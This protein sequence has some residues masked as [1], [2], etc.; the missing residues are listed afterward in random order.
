MQQ[1]K[2]N[3][4]FIF[5]ILFYSGCNQSTTE[6]NSFQVEEDIQELPLS[7]EI[8]KEPMH[9][10]N[11]INWV[12]NPQNGLVKIKTIDDLKFIVQYKPYE[13]IVCLEERSDRVP[14]TIM[15]NKVKELEGM[16]YF[17]LKILLKKN[18]GELL[19]S[20]INSPEDYDKRVKYFAFGM[21]NDIQLVDGNDTLPCAMYHFER[22]YDATPVCTLLLGFKKDNSNAAK[23]KTLLVYDRTFNKGLL[24]FT[25]KEN[26][27]H[28]LPKLLTL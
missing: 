17:D 15:R 8:R 4:F 11:Y 28:T 7:E 24:K 5:L 21:Q 18:E 6:K 19:K 2:N 14:G 13:Y 3:F 9:T 20:G 25:F 23:P 26:R 12:R 16:Q 22:S 27:L 10:D 1:Y